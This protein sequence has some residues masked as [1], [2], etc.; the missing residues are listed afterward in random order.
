MLD[1]GS[2][3]MNLVG[4]LTIKNTLPT[5]T[6]QNATDDTFEIQST[7][8]GTVA[9]I[10]GGTQ[11][12]HIGASGNMTITGKLTQS[13]CL[14]KD[15][16]LDD[17]TNYLIDCQDKKMRETQTEVDA[18][19]RLVLWQH[20]IIGQLQPSRQSRRSLQKIRQK[21]Q[22]IPRSSRHEAA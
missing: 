22:A 15:M 12:M 21:S 2:G 9:I 14:A 17:V 8:S 20:K 6:L 10:I 13:G 4:N 11:V 16:A 7:D 1:D 19:E 5:I 18:L 3:N